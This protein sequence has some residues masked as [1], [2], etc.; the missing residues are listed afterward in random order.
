MVDLAIIADDLTGALDAAAPFAMRG[1]T[2]AVA[3]GPE[4]LP[5]ALATGA[6]VVGVSTDS[7][8]AVA[9]VARE[10]TRAAVAAL[11]AGTRIFK[12][13]DSRLKGNIEAELDAIP[14]RSSLVVPAIPAF[15]RW[16]RDGRLGGFGVSAPIDI[17]GRLGKH[18]SVAAIPDTD[19]Q[20]QIDAAL[21][22]ATGLPVG[23]RGLAEAMARAMRPEPS[24]PDTGLPDTAVYCAIGSTD[25]ITVAQLDRLRAARSD[26]TYI[27][28]PNGRAP[29][30]LPPTGPVTVV[31]ATPGRERADDAAVA[32]A[33]AE[34]LARLAIAPGSLLV[35]SGGATAQAILARLGIE[36]LELVGEVLP[37][38]PLARGGGLT[39][40]TK[41][42]GF[43]D[44]DTLLRLLAPFSRQERIALP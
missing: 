18:A 43:G 32:D 24:L 29:E 16:T 10:R 27:A 9:D 15:G 22:T 5:E 20:D 14:H 25:P 7:R 2:T 38:L 28:A 4:A 12:K 19:T 1:L 13:V 17:A 36:V 11:P 8:E 35:L 23:A 40:I 21:T 26:L 31:Q 37:G 6:R 42:G 3:L 41:S 30:R 39:V 34:T 44:P 33:L